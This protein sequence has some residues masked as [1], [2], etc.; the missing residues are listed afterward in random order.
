MQDAEWRRDVIRHSSANARHSTLPASLTRR[1]FLAVVGALPVAAATTLRNGQDPRRTAASQ[2]VEVLRSV[3]G[4]PP[5]IV[6]EFRAPVAFQQDGSGQFFVFDRQGH[7][8]Y[9]I[10]AAMTGAWKIVQIGQEAGRILEPTAFALA[11]NGTFVVADRPGAAERLQFFARGGSLIGG[12]TLP[13]RAAETVVIDDLVLNGVGSLQYD[14]SSVFLSQ[15][16]TGALVAQYSPGGT[17]V[18]TFGALRA[19]GQ[20]A[21][22]DLHFALNSGLPLLDPRGGFC[23]VFQTG[24]PMFRKYDS[25]GTLLFERHVEGRE[26][27]PVVNGLPTQWPRRRAGDRQIPLVRPVV[28]AARLDA[29]GRLWISFAAVPF[30]YVYDA[31]GD[32]RRVV[33]FRAAGLVSPNSL[34][35]TGNGRLLV[36]PGC[37][38]FDPSWPRT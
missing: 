35:F 32:K 27:D 33:Q 29:G 17:P 13:G 7:T 16:E 11:Q 12:F 14:G 36:T 28:R 8:V 22:R 10:D 19:T 24:V 5:D 2:R 31:D 3:R 18:R 9:G 1:S 15:P 6:G 20:E 37:F 4:I 38:E 21:D 30:T 26:I 25:A 23:F 34:F